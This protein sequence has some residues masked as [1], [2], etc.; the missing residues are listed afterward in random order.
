MPRRFYEPVKLIRNFYGDHSVGY[1][2]RLGWEDEPPGC[3]CG[4]TDADVLEWCREAWE[5]ACPSLRRTLEHM[6]RQ[7]GWKN[8]RGTLA[9]HDALNNKNMLDHHLPKPPTWRI[10]VAVWRT[11]PNDGNV[12]KWVFGITP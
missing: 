3:E 7:P 10:R 9:K 8:I 11:R 4:M 5:R 12:R 6:W 1:R 2:K